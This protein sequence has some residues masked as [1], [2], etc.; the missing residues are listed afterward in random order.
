[1]ALAL[2]GDDLARSLSGQLSFK[3]VWQQEPDAFRRAADREGEEEEELRWAALERLPTYDRISKG[4]LK[5]AIEDGSVK[6][7]AIDFKRLKADEKDY[8]MNRVLHDAEKDH[9]SLLRRLRSRIDR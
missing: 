8:L 4:F 6:A 2:A 7:A 9:E 1:M 3:T 5:Q